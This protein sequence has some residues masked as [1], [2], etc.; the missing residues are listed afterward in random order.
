MIRGTYQCPLLRMTHYVEIMSRIGKQP[1]E[2]PRGVD[3]KV[4]QT[5]V[6]AQGPL[7]T[8]SYELPSGIAV[9]K[10]DTQIV[11]TRAT[12]QKQHKALHGLVRSLINNMVTGVAT[13]FTKTL[14]IEGIGYRVAK[15]GNAIMLSV[16]YSQP[17]KVVAP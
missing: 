17:V 8:L 11:V 3:V 7:G 4:E 14:Q 12:D 16:G 10:Q 6:T 5:R 9:N 1:I 2:I 15:E 13:G